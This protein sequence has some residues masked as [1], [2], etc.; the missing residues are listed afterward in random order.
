MAHLK[1]SRRKGL[2]QGLE[3]ILVLA[4]LLILVIFA[5]KMY[6]QVNN[7]VVRDACRTGVLA[8][9]VVMSVPAPGTKTV[10]ENFL[11][12]DCKTYNVNFYDNRVEINGKPV[13]VVDSSRK[14]VTK[15]FNGLTD[16]IVNQV[17]AEELRWCWYQFLEGQRRSIN[18]APLV[19]LPTGI[20]KSCFL[21]DEIRFDKSVTKEEFNGFYDYTKNNM[22]SGS[23]ITY[24]DYYAEQPRICEEGI[25]GSDVALGTHQAEF[26]VNC[27]EDYFKNQITSK[28]KEFTPSST[29]FRKDTPYV[30]LFLKYG[31]HWQGGDWGSQPETY[32]AYILPQSALS[33]QCDSL[34]RGPME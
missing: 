25:L 23:N 33:K 17:L 14:E 18:I 28:D 30:V 5:A 6:G 11:S 24:Y 21:C 27:W 4:V 20:P 2:T 15:K 3:I 22:M 29:V 16:D 34:G 1:A 8:Q 26:T 7:R 13:E 19:S 32:F 12:P 31:K 10:A 9:S